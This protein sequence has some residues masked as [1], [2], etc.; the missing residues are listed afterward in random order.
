MELHGRTALVTGAARRVGR[1]IALALA[2]RGADVVIH[3]NSSAS[4]ARQTVEAVERLGR[5]ASAIQADLAEPDQV[6]ALADRAVKAYGK[7]DVLVNSAAIF[8]RTALDQ[9]TMQDWDQ[10]LRVNLTGPFFLARRLGLLMRRQGMGKIINVADVAG[11]TPW[12]DF[13][14]YS[15]SKGMVITVTQ[16]LAKALAPEVQVN[17]VVPGTVLLAEEYSEQERES[18]IRRTPLKRIGDPADIAQTVL[19]L[20]EGSDFI[21]GQVVVV[22][23]GRSIQ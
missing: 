10:F 1:A 11:I 2:G 4:E 23:G 21:T 15:V 9:L 22:D 13:L 5:R 7:I 3:Y 20:V 18:I 17:A 16:G 19:F 8:R 6:E 14:P 12:A